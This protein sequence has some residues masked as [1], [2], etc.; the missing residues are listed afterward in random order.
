MFVFLQD[1]KAEGFVNMSSYSI[2]SA[3]EH[4]RK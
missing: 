4:K 1:E 3:G 2:E